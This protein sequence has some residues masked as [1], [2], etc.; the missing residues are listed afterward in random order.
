MSDDLDVLAAVRRQ[1]REPAKV[2]AATFLAIRKFIRGGRDDLT[3]AGRE[4]DLIADLAARLDDA[5]G[6]LDRL[7]KTFDGVPIVPG[8]V[9]FWVSPSPATM[10]GVIVGSIADG[11]AFYRDGDEE[12]IIPTDLA[13]STRDAA[14]AAS[15]LSP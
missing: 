11:V 1:L 12:L 9:V 8:D 6:R 2:D 4:V 3:L 14:L 7:A 15:I 5:M 13:C 10:E